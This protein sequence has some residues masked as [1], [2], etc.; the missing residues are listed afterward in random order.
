MTLIEFLKVLKED[1]P[2]F[3]IMYCGD[4]DLRKVYINKFV[5]VHGGKPVYKET[6]DAGKQPRVIGVKPVFIITDCDE[7]I[8]KPSEHYKSVKY[9]T[10]LLYTGKK[11]PTKA[12]EDVYNDCMVVIPEVTGEQATSLL[13]KIGLPDDII[14]YLKDKTG[15]VQE[16][17]LLG[18]QLVELSKDLAL[19]LESCFDIYYRPNLVNRNLDEEPTEFLN[20]ILQRKYND[21][22]EYLNGQHGNELFIY[23]SL[24]NWL[25]DIIKFCSCNDDY[26]NDAGLVAAKYRPLQAANVQR[27]PYLTLINLYEQGLRSM[28]SIKI[29]EADP[30]SALEVFVCYIIQILG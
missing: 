27:V 26:W 14:D 17:I 24:L 21:V 25:E 4:A 13:R 28:Q 16:A 15:S 29:N 1:K 8:K 30:S 12:V 22:F 9:P 11:K 2:K 10:L 19:D 6:I 3:I 23:A 20:A 5:A 18:R 7:P